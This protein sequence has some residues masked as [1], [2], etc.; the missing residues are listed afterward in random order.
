MPTREVKHKYFLTTPMHVD[1]APNC[2][3][4]GVRLVG[5]KPYTAVCRVVN[6]EIVDWPFLRAPTHCIALPEAG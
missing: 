4:L 6:G 5:D 1:R 3:I 2:K